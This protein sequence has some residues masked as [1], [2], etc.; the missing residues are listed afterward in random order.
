MSE[1]QPSYQ[2]YLL[3]L[4]QVQGNGQPVWRASLES[5][6]TKER[7]TFVSIKELCAFLQTQMTGFLDSDEVHT[8]TEG[9]S[10]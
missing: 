7:W 8:R 10:K 6:Q 4:W 3:R 1:K 9:G 2:S 5:A